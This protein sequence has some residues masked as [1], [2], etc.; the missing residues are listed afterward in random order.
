MPDHYIEFDE[1]LRSEVARYKL[2]KDAFRERVHGYAAQLVQLFC[3][4]DD[5]CTITGTIIGGFH[6]CIFFDIIS[7]SETRTKKWVLRVPIP[8]EHGGDLLD[9]KFRS[10]V[11]NMKYYYVSI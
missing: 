11:A 5:V 2:S 3:S 7:D 4:S 1:Q 10:E 8:G 9:E 6:I